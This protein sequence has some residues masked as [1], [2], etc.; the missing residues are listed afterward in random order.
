[1]YLWLLEMQELSL[2]KKYPISVSTLKIFQELIAFAKERV[3]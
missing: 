3:D 2:R 1:M